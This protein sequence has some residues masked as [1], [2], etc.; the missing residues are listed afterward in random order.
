M[1]RLE[2][3]EKLKISQSVKRTTSHHERFT[4]TTTKA[5]G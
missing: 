1:E 4:S 5:K 2:R 3:L